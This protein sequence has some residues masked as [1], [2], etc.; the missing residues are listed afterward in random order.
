MRRTASSLRSRAPL[1]L[2]VGL[3]LLAAVS[4]AGVRA[5]ELGGDG[6]GSEGASGKWICEGEDKCKSRV[7]KEEAT[8]EPSCCR[9]CKD[10]MGI[11]AS[12]AF[13]ADEFV[14]NNP[15]DPTGEDMDYSPL[16]QTAKCIGKDGEEIEDEAK[17]E[18]G[19]C[20][21]RSPR[22]PVPPQPRADPSH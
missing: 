18:E 1:C 7:L 6:S 9:I 11:P 4:G 20:R 5:P 19:E 21:P 16:D 8:D 3:I 14:G 2:S 13:G 22:S 10:D 15:D 17:K 12:H